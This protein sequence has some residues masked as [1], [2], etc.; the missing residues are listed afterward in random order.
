MESWMMKVR[1]ESRLGLER[2]EEICRKCEFNR[3]GKK[4]CDGLRVVGWKGYCEKVIVDLYS[5]RILKVRLRNG[6]WSWFR[7]WEW[8]Y[9]MC[10][11]GMF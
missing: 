11:L 5:G 4:V 10:E 3:F 6:C 1:V 7:S 9:R 2:L 8:F